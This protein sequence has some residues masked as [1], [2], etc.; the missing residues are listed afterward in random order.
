MHL[1]I[2]PSGPPQNEESITSRTVSMHWQPPPENQKNGIIRY[3]SV[4][5]QGV[6]V[7]VATTITT[8]D[9]WIIVTVRPFRT[10]TVTVAAVTVAEGVES[11]AISVTTL[12]D[13]E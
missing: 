1:C 11:H 9:L 7:V 6:G 5:I 10:Y 3:Y 13:G 4:H 2:A 12:E 8:E